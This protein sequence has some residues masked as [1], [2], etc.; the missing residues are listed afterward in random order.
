MLVV[1]IDDGLHLL[2]MKPGGHDHLLGTRFL[3]RLQLPAERARVADGQRAL[4]R[5]FG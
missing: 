2:G 1:R 5:F 3:E 4:R